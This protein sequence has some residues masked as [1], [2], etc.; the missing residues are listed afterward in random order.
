MEC[1]ESSNTDTVIHVDGGKWYEQKVSEVLSSVR[2]SMSTETTFSSYKL[3][4]IEIVFLTVN[5][6]KGFCYGIIYEHIIS[7]AKLYIYNCVSD[8]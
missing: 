2:T 6:L 3:Q 7:T 4:V 5:D 8:S 1:I